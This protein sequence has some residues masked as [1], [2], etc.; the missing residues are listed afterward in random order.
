M[1]SGPAPPGSQDVAKAARPTQPRWAHS[2]LPAAQG[3]GKEIS[4]RASCAAGIKYRTG[5]HSCQ[6][7]AGGAVNRTMLCGDVAERACDAR[8]R[9]FWADSLTFELH[10]LVL[11][12]ARNL[13]F[14]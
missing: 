1:G 7:E 6:A 13:K 14:R 12:H 3:S 8:A 5:R 11:S 2:P 10:D 9:G 4:F